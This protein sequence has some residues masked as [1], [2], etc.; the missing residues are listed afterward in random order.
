MK[1]KMTV[2]KDHGDETVLS[3]PDKAFDGIDRVHSNK[4]PPPENY[5]RV[6]DHFYR[7]THVVTEKVTLLFTGGRGGGSDHELP[8][9]PSTQVGR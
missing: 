6:I 8:D 2:F 1:F 9:P 5:A 7:Q 3:D 4:K